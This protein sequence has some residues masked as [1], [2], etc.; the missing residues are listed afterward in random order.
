MRAFAMSILVVLLI[1][2]L[3]AR[4]QDST[5]RFDSA[6]ASFAQ[7]T[8]VERGDHPGC[9]V[10]CILRDQREIDGA[11]LAAD[12]AMVFILLP[13]AD[14]ARDLS[15]MRRGIVRLPFTSIERIHKPGTFGD[16]I[17][18]V[19]GGALVGGVLP[20]WVGSLLSGGDFSEISADEW[21]FLGVAT[22]V[23]LAVGTAVG[24]IVG[25]VNLAGR[26]AHGD[27]LVNGAG[28]AGILTE[29]EFPEGPPAWM[30]Y[31]FVK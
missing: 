5:A 18:P 11:L 27:Q 30:D 21:K 4:G 29:A 24:I 3:I 8:L 6:A 2:P 14:T 16:F 28:W 12:S 20:I 7:D 19:G 1:A 26:T 15:T 25:L 22:V 13:F 9:R 17:R 10:E 23:T 31:V